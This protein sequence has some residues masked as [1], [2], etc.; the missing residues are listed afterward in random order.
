M[1]ILILYDLFSTHTN[2]V[3]D[4]LDAFRKYS[5][6]K[7]YY[8]H[9]AQVNPSIDLNQFDTLI[10][11]YSV[12]VAFN[13]IAKK[14]Y[15]KIKDCK[16]NKILFV[17][18]EYD[19][20][21]VVINT[22]K[23]LNIGTV[24]TCVPKKNIFKVYPKELKKTTKFIETLTGYSADIKELQPIKSNPIEER[25]IIV[26]YRGND[27]PFYYG[28]L[29]QEKKNIAK[30]M[31]NEC[32]KRSLKYDIEYERS[33][34]IYGKKWLSFLKSCKATLGTES[35]SNLF[36]FDNK[37]K[38]TFLKFE[39]AFPNKEYE[40]VRLSV[41][42]RKKEKKIMNQISPKIFEAISCKT[43]L[44]LYEGSYSNIIKPNIHFIPLKKDFSNI[45]DVFE[46]L[47]DNS[48]LQFIVD[49]AY[50][51]IIMSNRYSYR[52]FIDMFDK[53][54]SFT[55]KNIKYKNDSK[56]FHKITHN[57]LLSSYP[58]KQKKT[59]QI[60][61]SLVSIISKTK[62]A[63]LLPKWLTNFIKLLIIKNSV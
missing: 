44:V 39:E 56:I 49:R 57:K 35:G 24:Y 12:R 32:I 60:S 45:E 19:N 50:D 6:Y 27:L 37:I 14:F 21:N 3:F 47:S 20:T 34:R 9:G 51:H 31:K 41:L 15:K 62:L 29:G 58:L 13:L 10:I 59:Q 30:K 11:H 7:Y 4:H 63:Q 17:Q 48:Y 52:S 16:C 2:T 25:K 26:G 42:G 33:K 53:N 55:S 28:D 61:L 8:L 38:N 1:K 43:A 40:S 22:I 5:K 23:D 36:D 54:L 18:D 46:K